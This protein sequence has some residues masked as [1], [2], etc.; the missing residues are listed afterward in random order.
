MIVA[1]YVTE[2]YRKHITAHLGQSDFA[3]ARS[4]LLAMGLLHWCTV[5][6]QGPDLLAAVRFSVPVRISSI[7]IFPAGAH[8]FANAP[9]IVAETEPEAF[10]IDVFLNAH[11]IPQA[12]SKE[13]P[14]V[15]NALVPTLIAYAG[16]QVEYTVDM[17]NEHAT[18]L[19]ILKGKFTKL[20]MAIYGDVVSDAPPSMVKHE[21]QPL[22]SIEPVPLSKAIDP[23]ASSDPT[24]PARKFLA[25]MPDAPPLPLV[26]RLM[27]CLKPSNDDWDLPDFPYLYA[28]LESLRDE[29][30]NLEAVNDLLSR[31]VRD[32]TT[33]EELSAFAAK[34]AECISNPKDSNDAYSIARLFSISASQHPGIARALL[35]NLDIDSLFTAQNIDEETLLCLLEAASNV[36]IARHMNTEAFLLMLRQVQESHKADALTQKAAR[37]LAARVADWQCFEDSLTNMQGNFNQCWNML[38][39]IGTHES[40]MAIWLETMITHDDIATKLSDI[41]IQTSLPSHSPL[42][43]R[44]KINIT[45]HDAFVALVRALIGVGSVLAVWA[46]TDSVGNDACREQVSAVIHLWQGVDGYREIVNHLLLLRQQARRLSWISSDNEIP[47]Q[48]GILAEKII[49]ELAKDP[50]A[51]LNGDLVDTILQLKPKLTFITENELLS[52]RKIALVSED[53]LLA[54]VEELMFSSDRP[55]SLRRLRTLRVSLAI[56]KRE[57]DLP[58][59]EWKTLESFWDEGSPGIVQCLIDVLI[60]I[61]DDL[62]KHFVLFP[63]PPMNQ[64]VAEQLFLTADDLFQLI[65]QLAPVFPPTTRAMRRLVGATADIFACT[66]TADALFSQMTRVALSARG[67]RQGCLDIV[68]T[69]SAAGIVAEPCKAG[70][71]VVFK[72]L[73]QYAG[74]CGERDPALHLLQVFTLIDHIL[75]EPNV[76]LYDEGEPSHWVT[77]VL[78]SVLDELRAFLRLLDPENKVHVVKRLIRLDDGILGIGGWL[79]TEELKH[80]T[81]TIETLATRSQ[82]EN[83]KLVLQYQ[84][85]LSLQFV[86]GLVG[87]ES[88]SS[89]W[90]LDTIASTSSLSAALNENLMTL[91]DGQYTSKY[92]DKL[93]EVLVTSAGSFEPELQFTILL[94][95]LRV[96]GKG[97]QPHAR[98]G[99]I[100]KILTGL[101]TNVVSIEPLRLELGPVLSALAVQHE[102]EAETAQSVLSLFQW[103]SSQQPDT[104]LT[105]LCG[106]SPDSFSILFSILHVSLPVENNDTIATLEATFTLDENYHL[107]LP[108]VA[109]PDTLK[110]SV[111]DIDDLMRQEIPTP[112]TPSNGAKTP[113][114]LG[115][116][117][118]PPTAVLRSQVETT[119]LTKTYMNNDFR[120][121]RQTPSARQNTS[122]LPSMHGLSRNPDTCSAST[123]GN[124]DVPRCASHAQHGDVKMREEGYVI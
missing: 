85:A 88:S 114:I 36:D 55:L 45:S 104:K 62:N 84:V 57:L 90:A 43:F 56:V 28:D 111:H 29:E 30:L 116:I 108:S 1:V 15:P 86:L 119:G 94:A 98:I 60:S 115:V 120:E 42:Y 48:S 53:G 12:D 61:G 96:S 122:R 124:G 101:T 4:T 34:V 64:A 73:L 71:E 41:S 77:S 63:P 5:Q 103:L 25:L 17:G 58:K 47:R 40:S 89:K 26:I 10:Y 92:L 67:T 74:Q 79:L 21:V 3:E 83:H 82:K 110:L 51:V 20:S 105:V 87:P 68:H 31:P 109:L 24:L 80:M 70:A 44:N 13:K 39:N 37:R 113:D 93:I 54:A 75:P 18:R 27:F 72:A 33:E 106:V 49:C 107:P 121:L 123:D 59:G 112:T 99:D 8:P 117:I 46:W 81:R 7:R 6:P 23:S 16:R 52:L 69:L 95:A 97:A 65:T 66:D 9:D 38:Q 22:P 76:M 2:K 50:Q 102:M 118:S 32:E 11:P 78:P 100:A 91:L 19:M 35:R 14:R